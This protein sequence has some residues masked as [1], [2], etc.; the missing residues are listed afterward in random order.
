MEV[1]TSKPPNAQRAGGISRDN[2]MAAAAEV[3]RA[4]ASEKATS[5]ISVTKEVANHDANCRSHRGAEECRQEDCGTIL[6]VLRSGEGTKMKESK[7]LASTVCACPTFPTTKCTINTGEVSNTRKTEMI[8]RMWCGGRGACRPHR[9]VAGLS[10]ESAPPGSNDE[11][12]K[13][14][15]S[16]RLF[17]NFEKGNSAYAKVVVVRGS[18]APRG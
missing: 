11:Q 8:M 18:P 5:E 9:R 2:S 4:A 14:K 12:R 7:L 15:Q 16:K 13:A 1:A 3:G 6:I 17:D 10:H